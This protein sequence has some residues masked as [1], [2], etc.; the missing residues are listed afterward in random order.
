M[1]YTFPAKIPPK[2]RP[3]AARAGSRLDLKDLCEA[4]KAEK[5]EFGQKGK[6]N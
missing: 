2:G 1:T 6:K 4:Q 3:A 5:E